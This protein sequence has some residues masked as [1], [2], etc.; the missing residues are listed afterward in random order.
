[1]LK[2]GALAGQSGHYDVGIKRGDR[3]GNHVCL[4]AMT[5]TVGERVTRGWADGGRVLQLWNFPAAHAGED[6]SENIR[7]LTAASA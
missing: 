5:R 3:R 6:A 2:I 7:P 1:M 4:A